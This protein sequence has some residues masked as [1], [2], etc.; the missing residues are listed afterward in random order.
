MAPMD[1]QKGLGTDKHTE[2]KKYL[3]E[4]WTDRKN[5][6]KDRLKERQT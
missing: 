2:R 4:R 6:H 1:R 5:R 3:K